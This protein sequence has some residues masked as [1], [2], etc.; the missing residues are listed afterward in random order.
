MIRFFDDQG[1]GEVIID[2]LRINANADGLDWAEIDA[3]WGYSR[4]TELDNV[5]AIEGVYGADKLG[6]RYT[7]NDN[8]EDA[9]RVL[10]DLGI[11]KHLEKDDDK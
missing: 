10:K 7:F 11:T 2:D 8:R 9:I 5:L 3:L 1:D 4:L 6:F